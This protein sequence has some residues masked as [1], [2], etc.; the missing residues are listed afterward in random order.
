[1]GDRSGMSISADRPSDETLNRG[2]LA[3]LLWRQYKF[4]FGIN[5]VQFSIFFKGSR[6]R[7]TLQDW[8]PLMYSL[9]L[10]QDEREALA[11]HKRKQLI[12]SL[13]LRQQQ[14]DNDVSRR[15]K[16]FLEKYDQ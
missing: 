7:H 14:V 13:R 4:P 8:D 5:I 9:T 11:R 2:P 15:I 6:P 1:M 12:T 16:T 10:N 3:L